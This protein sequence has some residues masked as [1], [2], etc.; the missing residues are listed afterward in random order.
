MKIF[1]IIY[2]MYF[3]KNN[4]VTIPLLDTRGP[5]VWFYD[6][7]AIVYLADGR[8][9]ALLGMKAPGDWALASLASIAGS[10]GSQDGGQLC[11]EAPVD[12]FIPGLGIQRRR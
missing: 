1:C 3:S 4:I 10:P 9:R 7:I 5:V 11:Q 12:L 2:L 8:R 6:V